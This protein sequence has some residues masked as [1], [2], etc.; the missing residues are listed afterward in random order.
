MGSVEQE[1]IIPEV[2][3]YTIYSKS[4]CPNC[5]KVKNFLKAVNAPVKTVDCDEY[6]IEFKDDFLKFVQTLVGKQ[7]KIFPMVFF[8]G[9]YVGGYDETEKHY[10]K[11]SAF[12]TD[13]F[14]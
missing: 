6:L 9:K 1:F 14:F 2:R 12:S 11:Q 13:V 10:D 4:G 5:T 3:G 8:D 7:I